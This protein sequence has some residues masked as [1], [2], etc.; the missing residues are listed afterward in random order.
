MILHDTLKTYSNRYIGWYD[1]RK[2][3]LLPKN[4]TLGNIKIAGN[5]LTIRLD[6]G[7]ESDKFTWYLKSRFNEILEKAIKELRK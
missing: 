4:L 1:N 6:P 3:A 2:H 7:V 5:Y